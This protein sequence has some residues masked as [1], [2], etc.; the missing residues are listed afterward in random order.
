MVP[1]R[2]LHSR[3]LALALALVCCA[4]LSPRG[5]R[6]EVERVTLPAG[7]EVI[8][9]WPAGTP[10]AL[11]ALA[12]AP[13]EA[14]Q[15]VS[16]MDARTGASVEYRP[17]APLPP[18]EGNVAVAFE[19]VMLC[20]AGPATIAVPEISGPIGM[21]PPALAAEPTSLLAPGAP[22]PTGRECA[23]RVRRT[24][25]EARPENLAA[26]H[27]RG[28]RVSALSGGGP[29]GNSRFAPRVDGDF[30]G[31]TDTIIRWAACKWG[32]DAN[33]VR[34]MAFQES[35][36]RQSSAGARDTFGLLQL[37][38]NSHPQTYPEAHTSTAFNLDYGL[39]WWRTCYEG[40]FNWIP[41]EA[42]G[43]AWGCVG[44]W[45]A[46]R[47][48]SEDAEEYIELVRA[49]YTARSWMAIRS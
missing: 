6:A 21:P 13:A 2:S 27:T 41:D 28:K 14:V 45:L 17:G 5:V 33:I 40:Y 26:N 8:Q 18:G 25:W 15:S 46:G 29:E 39:A 35:S 7:C 32:I 23:A 16:R 38:A 34:A 10:L 31:T 3:G 1:I 48:Y 4:L 37:K 9:M 22:L 36:W 49:H 44:L 47:W 42:R 30:V 19:P 43:D 20:L 11:I 24:P 12:V